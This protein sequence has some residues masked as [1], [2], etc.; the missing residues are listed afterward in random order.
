MGLIDIK[1][2]FY[3]KLSINFIG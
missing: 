1:L 2:H 3:I